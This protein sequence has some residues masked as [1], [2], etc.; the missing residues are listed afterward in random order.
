MLRVQGG[1]KRHT[2]RTNVQALADFSISTIA[3]KHGRC[4][5]PRYARHGTPMQV[6]SL[7]GY[8]GDTMN[9]DAISET[10]AEI[11]N[12]LQT[13]A[14]DIEWLM[15]HGDTDHDATLWMRVRASRVDRSVQFVVIVPKSDTAD[16]NAIAARIITEALRLLSK[17]R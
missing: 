13:R 9:Q 6:L 10:D 11:R 14:P 5:V 8:V 4:M 17:Q 2:I 15:V 7:A 12:I 1:R 3:L 16:S